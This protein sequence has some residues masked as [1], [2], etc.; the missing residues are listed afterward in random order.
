MTAL[1]MNLLALA[2]RSPKKGGLPSLTSGD[3]DDDFF[4]DDDDNYTYYDYNDY[5]TGA[6]VS[7]WWIIAIVASLSIV[8]LIFFISLIVFCVKENR[9]K[10]RGEQFRAGHA[11]WKAFCVATGLWFW[12]WVFKKCGCCGADRSSYTNVEGGQAPAPHGGRYGGASA[13]N[14][15]YAQ[16]GMY[17][18]PAPASVGKFEPMGYSGAAGTYQQPAP[19]PQQQGYTNTPPGIAQPVPQ[20]PFV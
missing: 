2:T 20:Q 9:R 17:G 18:Q 14:T 11:V 7:A 12:I 5:E 8:F 10:H 6:Y 13:A 3:D 16:G 19:A 15:A 4:S 1:A